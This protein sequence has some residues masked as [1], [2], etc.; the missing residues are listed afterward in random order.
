MILGAAKARLG[1]PE[2]VGEEAPVLLSELSWSAP[3]YELLNIGRIP[4]DQ[5]RQAGIVCPM[6]A[7]ETLKDGTL[8]RSHKLLHTTGK[9]LDK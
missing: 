2:I 6:L 9:Y 1:N 4:P 7:D 3:F 5:A 8:I